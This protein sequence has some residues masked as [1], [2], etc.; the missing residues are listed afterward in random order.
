MSLTRRLKRILRSHLGTV[1]SDPVDFQT[2]PSARTS[3]NRTSHEHAQSDGS[4]SA[5]TS[6][7]DVPPDVAKRTG[8]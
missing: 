8:P 7:S 5:P 6:S 4:A 2:D 1:R 3:Y